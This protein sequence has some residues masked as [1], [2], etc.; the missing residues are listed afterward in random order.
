MT[1]TEESILRQ[2][3]LGYYNGVVGGQYKDARGFIIEH[4]IDNGVPCTYEKSP[5]WNRF[6]GND[7]PVSYSNFKKVP[8]SECTTTDKKLDFFKQEGFRMRASD[9]FFYSANDPARLSYLTVEEK[10]LLNLLRCS[11]GFV[12]KSFCGKRGSFITLLITNGIP[13]SYKTKPIRRKVQ[14][15]ME[16]IGYYDPELIREYRSEKERLLFIKQYGHYMEDKVFQDY[17][18]ASGFAIKLEE[19]H[20]PSPEKNDEEEFNAPK[21]DFEIHLLN[22]LHNGELDG[23]V[24][25]PCDN[26][27][28]STIWYCIEGGVIKKLKL[29]LIKRVFNG[30]E[31]EEIIPDWKVV[32]ILETETRQL[33]FLRRSG[34]HMKDPEVQAYSN[35]YWDDYWNKKKHRT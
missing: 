9:P 24:G 5:R 26:G 29:G 18:R 32:E 7:K 27:H 11:D 33:N 1:L 22:R 16:T 4:R 23:P 19:F 14:G 10:V 17:S 15:Q 13:A 34:C 25:T 8:G 3:E 20:S 6:I 2:L 30:D 35:Q 31:N 21:T 12:G 28:G